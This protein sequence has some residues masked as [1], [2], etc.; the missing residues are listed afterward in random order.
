[1]LNYILLFVG[2]IMLIKGAD[3]FVD[4]SSSIAKKFGI[5]SIVIGLTIV[6]MGTSAPEFSVSVQSALAGMNDMSIANV[7]GSNIFNLLV[8]LGCSAVINKLKIDN[9]KDILIMFIIGLLM[10]L[11]SVDG[12]LGVCD[13]LFLLT[14]FVFYILSLL[15]K[16]FKEKQKD[17]KEEKQKPISITI[18]LCAIGL[19]G[20]IW[21]GNLVVNSASVIAQQLGM[22]ENLVGLTV[23]AIGTS[24]PELVTSLVATKKGELDIAIGNVVGSNIFNMLLILGAASVI[25]PM[26]VSFFALTDL[27]FVIAAML[28]FIIL[29]FKEKTLNKYQGIFLVLMYVVYI[30]YTIIR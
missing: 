18:C 30:I 5:P 9:Y 1:M 16:A 13:G 20:I 10:L 26:T 6:A 23:V 28:T 11:C 8:V 19:T 2:F 27:V 21:G 4:S 7:V 17:T 22:S 29:T 15:F 25:N 14:I 12:T 3:V 24:L